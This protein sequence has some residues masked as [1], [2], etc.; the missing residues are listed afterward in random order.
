ML[1]WIFKP[2]IRLTTR[3]YFRNF[4]VTGREHLPEE[5][6]YILVANH[7]ATF[8]D[9]LLIAAH[10]PKKIYFL[11]KSTIFRSKLAAWVLPRLNMIPVYRK[12]DDPAQMGRNKD[13]FEKCYTHLGRKKVMLIFPEGVS[14]G[15]RKIQEIKTGAARIALGALERGNTEIKIICIGLNYEKNGRFQT[16]AVMHIGAPLSVKDY[17]EHYGETAVKKLTGEIAAQLKNLTV[18]I[19]EKETDI[20]V[21]RIEEIYKPALMSTLGFDKKDKSNDFFLA[22]KIA[23]YASEIKKA[24]PWKLHGIKNK[25]DEYFD[26]L[27]KFGIGDGELRRMQN[28]KFFLCR[29]TSGLLYLLLGLPLFLYGWLTN[30]L[31]YFMTSLVARKVSVHT[32]F[33]VAVSFAAG[34]FIYLLFYSG[35]LAISLALFDSFWLNVIL[36]FGFPLA[37]LFAYAH[38]RFFKQL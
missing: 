5:G 11:S 37:G 17:V 16:N 25:V 36:F 18:S 12:Q 22:R 32:E 38:F 30:A 26:Q 2:L 31:P 27:E 34:M 14:I 33:R 24:E 35:L 13:T 3:F 19:D 10:T 7:P 4:Q 1:Y 8:L 23:E 29:F 9:A 20:F 21:S 6:P 28:R 15:E